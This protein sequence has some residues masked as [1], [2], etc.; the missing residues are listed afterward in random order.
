MPTSYPDGFD[1]FGVPS[2]PEDTPLS[3]AGDSTRAHTTLHRD[4]GDAIEALQHNAAVKGH[5]HSGDAADIHKGAKLAQANTHE[6]ADT[7]TATT[8]KH[9]TLGVGA[10]QALPGDY[11]IDY[12]DN[13]RLINTPWRLCT[14]TARPGSPYP[15]LMI[16]ETDTDRVRAWGSFDDNA[17]FIGLNSLEDFVQ[18][19]NGLNL[20]ATEWEQ[21]YL[22]GNTTN[23]K[24]AVPD[25]N[26]A[27][28]IDAGN[29]TNTGYARRIKT[30]DKET[31]T[32][33]Q[34]IT[35]KTGSTLIEEQLPFTEDASNDALLRMNADHSSYIRVRFVETIVGGVI[36]VLWTATGTANEAELG[37][38]VGVP[39][40]GAN[41]DWVT[42][43]K[44]RTITVLR[45]GVVVATFI[46]NAAITS[47]GEAY[48][49]WGIAAKVGYRVFG[50]STPASIS[51]VRI[52]DV[53]YYLSANRW[54]I[55][56]VANVP[57]CRLRQ[58]FK[59]GINPG[60]TILQW[61][62]IV[63][64]QF[65]YFDLGNPTAIT[66]KEPGLYQIETAIQWDPSVVP[67]TATV[68][69]CI[70]GVETAIRQAGYQRGGSFTPG[71]SQTLGL[72]GKLRFGP[73]DVLTVKASYVGSGGLLGFIFSFFDGPTKINSRI[74][75][76]Y[77]AP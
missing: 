31:Q 27:S 74:D 46:D 20:G 41:V 29:T 67:D 3:S 66:I 39:I 77:L 58:S 71:F 61:G 6:S 36:Q 7:D 10:N 63:E 8:A 33:D 65:G 13:A 5:D 9:H 21:W 24:F 48:R 4:E 53:S 73:N 76:T 1:D 52:Q 14:S 40:A 57:N 60:G 59:Q 2:L 43:I 23:G 25:G 44:D 72:A 30:E 51:Q 19:N 54:T 56:P 55:L 11:V 34:V 37:R 62:E 12:Q 16:Y 70:N 35:W 32:D 75:L 26:N 22:S 47:K 68:V 69:L 38:V 28:W 50:Q 15:G 45:D 18:A 42:Q 49:G 64:D 17:T